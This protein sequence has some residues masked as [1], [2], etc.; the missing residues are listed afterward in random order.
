M[1]TTISRPRPVAAPI[2][3]PPRLAHLF[4]GKWWEWFLPPRFRQV[5]KGDRALC[6]VVCK[7]T[8]PR[9]GRHLRRAPIDI[10][11]ICRDLSR[12]RP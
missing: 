10:C 11:V 9:G 6:G 2:H 7:W 12:E 3:Q 8:N 4:V 5:R 1:T